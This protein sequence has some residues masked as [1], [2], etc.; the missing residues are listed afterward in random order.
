MYD[1]WVQ[2]LPPPSQ[3]L[4]HLLI[5]TLSRVV[6]SLMVSGWQRLESL[7][8]CHPWPE[9]GNR[10]MWPVGHRK[11]IC[12]I[13][14]LKDTMFYINVLA[15][16]MFNIAALALKIRNHAALD[17]CPHSHPYRDQHMMSYLCNV[18]THQ[19]ILTKINL[20]IHFDFDFIS[21]PRLLPFSF[22]DIHNTIYWKLSSEYQHRHRIQVQMSEER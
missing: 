17:P 10:G 9:S 11:C 1:P 2:T 8:S 4:L 16:R 12:M 20:L 7:P 21:G 22:H 18:S 19:C 13:L 5:R 6:T 14:S 15:K 3:Y